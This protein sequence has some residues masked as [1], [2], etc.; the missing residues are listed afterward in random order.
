MKIKTDDSG[1]VLGY[2]TIGGLY[3]AEEYT[4]ELPTDFEKHPTDYRLI[5]SRLV[6][7]EN[8]KADREEKKAAHEQMQAIK[9]WFAWY[10]VQI[11][12]YMRS[13]R[14]GEE[15]DGDIAHL[16]NIA[17]DYQTQLR[18]LEGKKVGNIIE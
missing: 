12:Q 9:E 7:D 10:D 5:G 1:R 6:L 18:A 17:K 4:G 3:G 11:A 16:D 13:I 14:M 8:A 15:W 2:V